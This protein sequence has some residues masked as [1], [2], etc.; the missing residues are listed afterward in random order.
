MSYVPPDWNKQQCN[1]QQQRQQPEIRSCNYWYKHSTY[2]N[3]TCYITCVFGTVRIHSRIQSKSRIWFKWHKSFVLWN[4]SI[5][6]VSY[7]VIDQ[8]SYNAHQLGK[9]SIL[10]CC[11]CHMEEQPVSVRK[12]WVAIN[13]KKAAYSA[14]LEINLRATGRHLPYGITPC[15]LP[16]DTSECAPP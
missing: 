11:S 15:Y 8:Q 10:R 12:D 5:W 16:S 7:V 13:V 4:H 3:I 1:G 2:N 14:S 9:R 6:T